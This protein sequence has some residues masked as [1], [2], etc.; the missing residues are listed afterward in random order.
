MATRAFQIKNAVGFG[1]FFKNIRHGSLECE[2]RNRLA[3]A[4]VRLEH[5]EF[6]MLRRKQKNFISGKANFAVGCGQSGEKC[7]EG[8]K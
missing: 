5:V 8:L 1:G 6:F 7:N 2:N 4:K 3:S